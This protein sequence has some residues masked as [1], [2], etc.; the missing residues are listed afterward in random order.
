V[1]AASDS[2]EKL[3]RA[4]LMGGGGAD[5]MQYGVPPPLVRARVVSS[6]LK[7]ES[8]LVNT[9]PHVLDVT[10][11]HASIDLLDM[12]EKVHFDDAAPTTNHPK[13]P[14]SQPAAAP[15]VLFTNQSARDLSEL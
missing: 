3:A 11:T 14:T 12:P 13:A 10:A 15:I 5:P 4:E 6:Y 8:S 2:F 1:A 7:N 9:Y